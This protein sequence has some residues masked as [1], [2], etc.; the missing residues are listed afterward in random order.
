V[1]QALGQ[2]STTEPQGFDATADP[3]LTETTSMDP[4]LGTTGGVGPRGMGGQQR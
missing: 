2:P 4:G 3:M 1:N